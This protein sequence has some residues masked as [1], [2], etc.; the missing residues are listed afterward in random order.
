MSQSQKPHQP[1]YS[2]V[3]WSRTSSAQDPAT[4]LNERIVAST[5]RPSVH[6]AFAGA[7]QRG[8]VAGLHCLK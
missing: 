5:G 1:R 7:A 2:S 3:N 8:V 6:V 4:S